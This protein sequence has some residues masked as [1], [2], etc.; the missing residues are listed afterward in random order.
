MFRTGILIGIITVGVVAQDVDSTLQEPEQSAQ[1]QTINP[2]QPVPLRKAEKGEPV[3]TP[4]PKKSAAN[5]EKLYPIAKLP[6]SDTI[7]IPVLDFD[8]ADIRDVL[9]GLGMQYN[10]NIFLEPEV[11]GTISLYLSDI[12]LRNAID[13]IVKRSDYAYTVENEIVKV[14]KYEEPEPPPLPAGAAL[15]LPGGWPG[16]RICPNSGPSPRPEAPPA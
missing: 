10:V 3:V 1:E 5:D 6:V 13:F 8:K 7:R 15:G 12:S 4:S 9:R 11:T 14:Y 2:K 16:F